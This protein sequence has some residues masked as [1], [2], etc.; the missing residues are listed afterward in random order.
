M[1]IDESDTSFNIPRWGNDY[2]IG[3]GYW[4]AH[5]LT[6][7]NAAADQ[8][9]GIGTPFDVSRKKV[10]EVEVERDSQMMNAMVANPY[11]RTYYG[12]EYWL[13][14]RRVGIGAQAV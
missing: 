13:Y 3:V 7:A 12:Q 8:V 6:L 4:V 5:K 11:L 9:G 2:E 10:G 14:A 1:F